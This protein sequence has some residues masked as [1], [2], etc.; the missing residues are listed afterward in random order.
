MWKDCLTVSGAI[1]CHYRQSLPA[2]GLLIRRN[3][4]NRNQGKESFGPADWLWRRDWA[5]G[6]FQPPRRCVLPQVP[7]EGIAQP[8]R[9]IFNKNK[10][11][12]LKNIVSEHGPLMAIVVLFCDRLSRG[13]GWPGLRVAEDDL[14]SV[15]C[16]HGHLWFI[17]F[18]SLYDAICQVM[19]QH[20]PL[21]RCGCLRV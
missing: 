16:F 14:G 10:S 7:A 11:D 20:E 21:M 2:K 18:L 5:K 19:M 8:R 13:S 3:M 9:Y 4:E 6:A 17:F 15:P 12:F 1:Y